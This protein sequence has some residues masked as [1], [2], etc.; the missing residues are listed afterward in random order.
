V[1]LA[2]IATHPIQYHAPV[3]QALARSERLRLRVFYTWSQTAQGA[4][5]DSGFRQ[6]VTWDIPLLEGYPF[7]FVANVARRPGTERF[8][9]LR[10]PGLNRAISAWQPDA[11]LVLGWYGA[12]HLSALRHFKNRVPVLFRGESTLLDPIPA[13]R[14]AARRG[15]L[16][17]VYRHVDMS[18]AL[19]SNNRDYYRW[20]GVPEERIALAPYVIDTERFADPAGTHQ[21]RAS[22]WRQELGIATDARVVLFAGKLQPKK[23][24]LLLLE[25]F[26]A[27][28]AAGELVFA[29]AGVLEGELRARA[30]G[31]AHVHF[32]PFQNQQAMPAV[33]RLGDVFVLPSRGPGETWG[34]AVNEAMACAR[35]TIASDRVGGAR[36]LLTEGV[37]GWT[38]EAGNREGLSAAL[39]RAL[40]CEG[41]TLL[42]IGA[43]AQRESARW[44]IRAAAEGIEDAVLRLMQTR[45]IEQGVHPG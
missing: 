36:D 1:A 27:C 4:V 23:D 3:F 44:S 18:I 6:V 11:I 37:T 39:R 28:G 40:T 20:C 25:A 38:F 32:L 30:Q 2:V 35:A 16:R 21:R 34:L 17:W 22:E 14:K 7:E 8:W 15:F 29:G 24:P 9:G 19:G 33:Y 41:R 45:S 42:E 26:L 5:V 12:S 10:N 13:W 43:A 31:H